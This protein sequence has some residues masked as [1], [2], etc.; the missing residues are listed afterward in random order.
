MKIVFMGTPDIAAT[1]LN[2]LYEETFDIAAVVT[3]PD[4]P[5]GRSGAPVGSPVKE[6]ALRHGTEILQPEKAK[7]PAFIARLREIAPDVIVVAAYG[8]ILKKA[9]LDIPPLGC[10]NVHTSLLPKYRGAAPINQAVID[11]CAV[12][13]V[14]T[15][16]MDEGMD[17]G[18][19]LL[20]KEV[21]LD[22]KETAGTLF[23][24]L[25][26]AGADLTVETLFGLQA[27]SLV[28]RKQEGEPSYVHM[29]T[30]EDGRVDWT[31]DAVRIERL[32]R[33]LD[34]WPGAYSFLNGK[35]IRLI[36]AD[37]VPEEAE[38]AP[39]TLC[40]DPAKELC[41]N[42]GRGRLRITRLQAEG[43]KAMDA[44][45]FLRGFSLTKESRFTDGV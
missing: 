4:R 42:T 37:V 5:K 15:M 19:I 32:I 35:R 44:A 8:H 38:G 10:V 31:A 36:A 18:D 23:D 25:A 40:G 2:R 20:Q 34:P 27:G 29:M 30:K 13:G 33:G 6:A 14:T 11:G 43:K 21:P 39:G 22:P 7:D 45:D 28:P 12:T 26:A 41:V 17:T 1:V 3:N 24:K 9:V 16:L